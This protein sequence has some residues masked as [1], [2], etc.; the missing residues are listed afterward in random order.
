MGSLEDVRTFL[1]GRRQVVLNCR[2]RL[3]SLQE[4]FESFYGE[5]LRAR[6]H[7]L[8]QLVEATVTHPAELPSWY[9]EA[10][11][12]TRREVEREYDERL[13]ELEA[14]RD[15]LCE[16]AETLRQKSS[17]EEAEVRGRNVELDREEEQLKS[18][19]EK[20]LAR[21]AA[22]NE[23]IRSLGKGFGFFTH[24]L[25]MRRLA[26][27][28][29]ALEQE[30]RDVKARVEQLRGQWR[31]ADEEHQKQERQWRERW[32]R[33]QTDGAALSA[34]LEALRTERGRIVA[35][36]TVERILAERL[37]EIPA[38]TEGDPPCPRCEMTNSRANHFCHICAQRLGE[39][40]ED[41]DGSLKEITELNR[42]FLRF[43]EGMRACQ[44]I[45]GLVQGIITGHEALIESVK[46]MQS[47]QSKH[48]LSR[49]SIEVH[50]WS[51][52]FGAYFDR[53]FELA[54]REARLH[55]VDFARSIQ[56][57]TEKVFTEKYIKSY[58]ELIGDELSRQAEAQWGS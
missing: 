8:D 40:R 34:K 47:S 53:L 43:A 12:A 45:M 51:R 13:A 31:E 37:P 3:S 58:F 11:E 22:F 46:D 26:A 28:K 41:F 24:L 16:E 36:T 6:E 17:G 19:N 48:K 10:I 50:E 42:H 44:E 56:H 39:D 14:D 32:L 29:E 15:A 9:G 57:Q 38:P 27:E 2:D 1:L 33:L 20:L 18:R 21:I 7:E 5:V 52:D 55:P 25:R 23:R 54:S 49:L 30:Q 35:R 4:R